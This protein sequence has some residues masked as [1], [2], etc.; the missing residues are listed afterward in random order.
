MQVVSKNECTGCT[1]CKNIC[2][3]GAI[4]MDEDKN[5]FKYPRIDKNKC[6]N[7]G[8][9]RKKCPINEQNYNKLKNNYICIYGAKHKKNEIREQSS[10]GGIFTAISDYILKHN[11]VIYGAVLDDENKVR[12]IRATTLEERNKLR[13]SKYVQSELD[14]VFQLIKNDLKDDKLV[15]FVGTP[16]QNAG[17]KVYL[18]KEYKNLLQCDFVCHGV[19]SPLLWEEFKSFL[20]NKKNVKI[21]DFK[22]RDKKNG[23]HTHTESVEFKDGTVD[24][25]SM[26]SQA[27]KFMFMSALTYRKSC[28]ECKFTTIKRVSDITISDYWGIEKQNLGYDDNK[29]VSLIIIN[30]D[31]GKNCFENIKKEID[32][33]EAELDSCLQPQLIGP[34]KKPKKYDKF[35]KDYHNKGYEYVLKKYTIYGFKNRLIQNVK[36]KTTKVVLKIIPKGIKIKIKQIISRKSKN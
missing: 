23:W 9:C 33:I 24:N 30:T 15:L 5:G 36:I 18:G 17:L 19:P 29:G 10:S 14:N 13:G 12:H 34:V 27:N 8:L 11:G 4:T 28:Y 2:P 1:L 25:S 7:C 35:W 21:K 26:P 3:K 31:K 32:Y 16:C 22:F 20:E 6:I